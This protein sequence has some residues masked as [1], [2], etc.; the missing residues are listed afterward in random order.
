MTRAWRMRASIPRA[1]FINLYN[2]NQ[3]TVFK[4]P[5]AELLSN[6]Y[7]GITT[8]PTT[9]RAAGAH[10]RIFCDVAPRPVRLYLPFSWG[11]LTRRHFCTKRLPCIWKTSPGFS[12]RPVASPPSWTRPP[13]STA[14]RTL[15]LQLAGTKR[16]HEVSYCSFCT[17]FGS[18]KNMHAYKSVV[19]P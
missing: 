1:V 15:R 10:S 4:P 8:V 2:R 18:S 9:F 19:N 13:C 5:S 11:M 3:V 14:S 6:V 7:P 12:T 16:K 17:C